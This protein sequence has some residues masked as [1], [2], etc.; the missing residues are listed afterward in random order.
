MVKRVCR[1]NLE[2]LQEILELQYLA[3]QSEAELFRS[4]D[5]PPLKQTLDEV[6]DEYNEGIILKMIDNSGHIIGSVRAKAKQGTVYI[7]KLMVHPQNR[8]HGYGTLL[9]SEIENCFHEKRYELFTST[10]S[11]DNI[12]LY[13]KAGYRIFNQKSI[14]DEL[15]FVYLEKCK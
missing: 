14:N 15:Q 7:G 8:H 13:Q 11:K 12:R 10:R 5:I 1:A 3:Y 2:D 4:R 6:I 9:L